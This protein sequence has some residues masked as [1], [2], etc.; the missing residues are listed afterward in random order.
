MVRGSVAIAHMKEDHTA[1]Y[2]TIHKAKPIFM[3]IAKDSDLLTL[4][5]SKEFDET[6]FEDLEDTFIDLRYE[7]SREDSI[8]EFE[9]VT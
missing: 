8:S 1:V 7:E 9:L 2:R 6:W 5:Y 3:K 4:S